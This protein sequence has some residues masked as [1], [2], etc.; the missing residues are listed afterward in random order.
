[1]RYAYG[2]SYHLKHGRKPKRLYTI[3]KK[4][5]QRCND[6]N[7]INYKNYGGRG[8]SICSEWNDFAAFRIWAFNNG[9]AENLTLDRIDNDLGY[10]PDNCRW[11]TY[12]EQ[13]K[14]RR[15]TIY[16]ECNGETKTITEWSEISKIPYGT[17]H[18]RLSRGWEAQRAIFEA[19]NHGCA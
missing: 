11:S 3:W 12:K 17:I 6:H 19:I 1:M 15:T 18:G 5:R 13:A 7:A 4:M 8:I 14:N 2:N 16:I 9:Y 10:S